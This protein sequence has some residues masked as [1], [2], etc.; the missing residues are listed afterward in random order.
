MS[1]THL[2]HAGFDIRF[3]AENHHAAASATHGD[4]QPWA[5]CQLNVVRSLLDEDETFLEIMTLKFKS[6][7]RTE[8][9]EM[10]LEQG[11]RGRRISGWVQSFTS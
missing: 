2:H 3:L 1:L 7:F 9:Q 6:M 11:E 5:S 10:V 4:L 8:L